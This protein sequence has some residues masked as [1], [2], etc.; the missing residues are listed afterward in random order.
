MKTY[1]LLYKDKNGEFQS[2]HRNFSSFSDAEEWLQ[3]I[4]A[5]DW[6]IGIPD[7]D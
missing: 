7:N 2:Q 5:T 6:E 1:H 4:G 3:Y